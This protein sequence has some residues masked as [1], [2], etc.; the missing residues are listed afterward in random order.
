MIALFVLVALGVVIWMMWA[1]AMAFVPGFASLLQRP[2]GS[3]GVWPFMKGVE[4][5]GG[6]YQERSTLLVLHHKRG[7]HSLG[8]LIVAMQPRGG[9]QVATKYAGAFR[10]WIREPAAREAWDDLELNRELKLSFDEGWMRAT[11]QPIG[12]FMF[13]GRFDADRWL[14]VLRSMHTVVASL[15]RGAAVPASEPA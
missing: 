4:T 1:P 6:E 9:T 7:R 8:Y 15:E 13:P 11:W 2:T 14:G 10:E 3:F 5:I 12:P